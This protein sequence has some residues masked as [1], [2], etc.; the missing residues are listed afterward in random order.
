[1]W[2]CV[3]EWVMLFLLLF[4]LSVNKI[5]ECAHKLLTF[6]PNRTRAYRIT[7]FLPQPSLRLHFPFS[8][9]SF[10]LHSSVRDFHIKSLQLCV[11][12]W[13]KKQWWLWIVQVYTCRS[14]SFAISFH[15]MAR[16]VKI[17]SPAAASALHFPSQAEKTKKHLPLPLDVFI[18]PASV[19]MKR[20][21]ET[22]IT[23]ISLLPGHPTML[24]MR[25][26]RMPVRIVSGRK[27]TVMLASGVK[28][29]SSRRRCVV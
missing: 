11:C 24:W 26:K 3:C 18:D 9:H 27:E 22:E 17:L 15:L 25:E 29:A 6:Q 1:M 19:H 20:V 28:A 2:E 14:I 12:W 16:M 13:M 21:G 8:S 10:P 4:H 7:Y 5:R 23:T